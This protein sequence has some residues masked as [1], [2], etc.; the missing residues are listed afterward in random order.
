L[1]LLL[2]GSH[3]FDLGLILHVFSRSIAFNQVFVAALLKPGAGVLLDFHGKGAIGVFRHEIA[4]VAVT[5][6]TNHARLVLENLFEA[7]FLGRYESFSGILHLFGCIQL[8][9]FLLLFLL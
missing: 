8:F 1:D 7:L 5:C 9:F 6:S 2:G 4:I 3:L